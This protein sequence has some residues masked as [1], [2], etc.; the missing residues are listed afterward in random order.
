MKGEAIP[1]RASIVAIAEAFD[2]MLDKMS[3]DE[4][5]KEIEFESGKS[6]DPSLV[7]VFLEV[8]KRT[9]FK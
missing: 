9:E 6:F 7:P 3:L 5:I 4:I 1:V 2:R 8:I